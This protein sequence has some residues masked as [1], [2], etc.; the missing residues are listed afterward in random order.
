[1]KNTMSHKHV[2]TAFHCPSFLFPWRELS[3]QEKSKSRCPN[4]D[5]MEV[6]VHGSDPMN[7]GNGNAL[8][9]ENNH[10]PMW[11]IPSRYQQESMRGQLLK[12]SSIWSFDPTLSPRTVVWPDLEPRVTHPP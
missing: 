8:R 6:D 3:S 2:T 1:M 9:G 11:R 10:G 12:S 4:V 7:N 5:G